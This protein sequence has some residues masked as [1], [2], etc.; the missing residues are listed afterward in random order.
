MVEA[1]RPS[2]TSFS[3]ERSPDATGR[4]LDAIARRWRRVGA[5][6][7]P[8]AV[9]D[10]VAD[11]VNVC[12]ECGHAAWALM[13]A[14]WHRFADGCLAMLAWTRLLGNPVKG[15]GSAWSRPPTT[16]NEQPLDH[17]DS[18]NGFAQFV[19]PPDLVVR[20]SRIERT[21]TQRMFLIARERKPDNALSESFSVLGSIGNVYTV[22][23]DATPTCT[24]PDALKGNLCKHILFVKLK[25]LRIDPSSELIYAKQLTDDELRFAFSNACP[26][27]SA[28]ASRH[29]RKKFKAVMSGTVE[30]EPRGRRLPTN[31]DCCPICYECMSTNEDLVYCPSGCH[32]P[33]HALCFGQWRSACINRGNPVTCVYCRTGWASAR[34]ANVGPEGYVNLADI[35]G[36]PHERDTSSYRGYFGGDYDSDDDDRWGS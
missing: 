23:I 28:V 25:V 18:L 5:E 16:L 34:P 10:A 1:A 15:A 6:R 32:R 13:V 33:I 3:W 2:R 11:D 22:T 17:Y 12:V 7:V 26:D 35:A 19:A 30:D 24:C 4:L 14:R 9:W 21:L 31:D 29:V 20:Q 8:P 27:P 36:L